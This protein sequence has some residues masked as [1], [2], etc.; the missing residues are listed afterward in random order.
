MHVAAAC[1]IALALHL[2]PGS[3]VVEHATYDDR[4]QWVLPP[5]KLASFA[6]AGVVITE[7][8]Q[9]RTVAAATVAP[10]PRDMMTLNGTIDTTVTDVPRHRTSHNSAAFTSTITPRNDPLPARGLDLE[11]AGMIDLPVLPVCLGQRWQTSVPVLTT[12]GSGM[13]SI[14]HTVVSATANLV[15]IDVK[16]T[17]AITGVEYNLPHLLPGTLSI[18]GK[19]WFDVV[20]GIVSQESYVIRNRLIKTVHDKTIGFIET[21]TVD[22]T[23][24]VGRPTGPAKPAPHTTP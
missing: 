16:G 4:V 19:A 24:H 7:D 22:V 10:T 8:K 14:D 9:T 11:E 12:L 6:R 20:N 15:E 3:Y 21:E 1:A 13:A 17:G 2:Q 18:T 5:D 23:T